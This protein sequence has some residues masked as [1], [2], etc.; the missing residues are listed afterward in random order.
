MILFRV[1][2][3]KILS[4]LLPDETFSVGRIERWISSNL[5]DIFSTRSAIC[6]FLVDH[7]TLDDFTDASSETSFFLVDNI[8]SGAS[9]D[10]SSDCFSGSFVGTVCEASGTISSRF[11][12][13]G[14]F[15]LSSFDLT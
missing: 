10:D 14:D 8:I 3:S 7:V 13:V 12:F 15:S 4:L 2:L 9:L 6:F 11:F 5:L 1:G